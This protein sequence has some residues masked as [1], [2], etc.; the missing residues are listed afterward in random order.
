MY[1]RFQ[2]EGV[3]GVLLGVVSASGVPQDQEVVPERVPVF[4]SRAGR[5]LVA[6]LVA[7]SSV[8]H[9][10]VAVRGQLAA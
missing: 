10:L 5:V 4:S 1:S 8:L 2:V 6:V 7:R 9:V 3:R